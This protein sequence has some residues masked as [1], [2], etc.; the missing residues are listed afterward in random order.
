M[1][2][3]GNNLKTIKMNLKYLFITLVTISMLSCGTKI[4]TPKGQVNIEIPCLG[5]DF[6]SSK[7]FIRASSEG[8]S[9]N[10]K[11]AILSA[12]KTAVR[13]L[14]E[15]IQLLIKSVGETFESNV[16]DGQMSSYSE[17]VDN[18]SRTI[19][20][21]LL[22]NVKTICSKTT[23]DI[24]TNMYKHYTSIEVSSESLI[25]KVE[26]N[27]SREARL[28]IESNRNKFREIFN[29]ELEKLR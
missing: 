15:K 1:I 21:G 16:T 4:S 28:D 14:Q 12:E 29:E 20:K 24:Q 22:S 11:G 18:I 5:S 13:K 17:T 7:S 27:L 2:I 9:N 8:L 3:F 6:E 26:N 10:T 19:S 23:Q 25:K